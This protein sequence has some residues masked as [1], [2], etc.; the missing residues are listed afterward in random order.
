V[1]AVHVA[2]TATFVVLLVPQVVVT[3]LLPE[4]AVMGV[5]LE[6]P[7]G[8]VTAGAGQVVAVQGVLVSVLLAA[9]AAAAVQVCTGVGPVVMGGGHVMVTQ[10]LPADAVWGVQVV[11]G[12]GANVDAAGCATK[13]VAAGLEHVVVVQFGETGVELLVQVCTATFDVSFAVQVV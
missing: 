13:L 1:A 4:V 12:C 11:D 10:L 5:Q 6:T 7:V 9:V 2:L 3:Q 8:P